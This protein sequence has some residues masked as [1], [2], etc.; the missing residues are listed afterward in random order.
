MPHAPEKYK[1]RIGH[2]FINTLKEY[3]TVIFRQYKLCTI[4]TT[5]Y[6]FRL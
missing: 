6:K 5:E 3:K 4:W 1:K 2:T